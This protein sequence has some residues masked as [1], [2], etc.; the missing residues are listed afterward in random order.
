MAELKDKTRSTN[1]YTFLR[2]G[3]SQSN[4]D[5]MISATIGQFGDKLTIA[6]KEQSENI[7]KDLENIDIIF[8]SPFERT[9]QT[10]EIVAQGKEI[11]FDDRLKEI[12]AGDENGKSWKDAKR[13]NF[14]E[15][16][17]DVKKRVMEFIYEIDEKYSDKNIL[18]VAHGAV[19]AFLQEQKMED[20]CKN[21]K[22][23]VPYTFDF[24]PIP[25]DKNYELDY[26]R[27]FID[28]ISFTE[29]G[30]KYEHIKEVFDGWFESGSMPFASKH[31]PFENT[32]IFD[33]KK[34]IG[35]PA[36]FIAEGQDQ[37]RG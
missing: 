24:A 25:H 30:K 26:H 19:G 12:N 17:T 14:T 27:P 9:R 5:G 1:S 28:K 4:V 37:T 3:E 8:A 11:I 2:H 33:P 13:E 15:N 35:Y 31:Y 18:I 16:K 23:A 6:G 36:D 32:D 20:S 29:N 7:K 21:I 10:A 22:N 34:G